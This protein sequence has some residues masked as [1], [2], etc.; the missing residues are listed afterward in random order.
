M[1]FHRSS[2]VAR[3]CVRL[4][5]R[6]AFRTHN[7]LADNFASFAAFILRLTL[8]SAKSGPRTTAF[9]SPMTARSVHLRSRLHDQSRSA[10]PARNK[11]LTLLTSIAQ[12]NLPMLISQK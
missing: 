12:T 5:L 1:L 10:R 11:R 3:R 7:Q 8:E 6:R 4:A 9:I 2:V